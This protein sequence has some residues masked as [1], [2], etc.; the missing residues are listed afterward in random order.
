MKTLIIFHRFKTVQSYVWSKIWLCLEIHIL[1]FPY[2]T[3]MLLL[4]SITLHCVLF[5]SCEPEK[6]ICVKNS[7]TFQ[8]SFVEFI[9]FLIIYCDWLITTSVVTVNTLTNLFWLIF[10]G[11]YAQSLV[12]DEREFVTPIPRL[13]EFIWM[14]GCS[15]QTSF[16]LG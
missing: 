8:V 16:L 7:L 1:F 13:L 3:F 2:L 5:R 14:G 10:L 15:G 9:V 11:L 6:F 12:F 4:N